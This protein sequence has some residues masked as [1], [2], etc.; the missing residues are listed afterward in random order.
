MS[1]GRIITVEFNLNQV[2]PVQNDFLNSRVDLRPNA[3]IYGT[4]RVSER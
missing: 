2:F 4:G 1:I 3:F